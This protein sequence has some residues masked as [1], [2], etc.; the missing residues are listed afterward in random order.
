MGK[1]TKNSGVLEVTG[2]CVGLE[3][4]NIETRLTYERLTSVMGEC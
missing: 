2:L 4:L 3:H 1:V